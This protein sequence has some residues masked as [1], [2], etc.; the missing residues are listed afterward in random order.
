MIPVILEAAFRSLLMAAAVWAGIRM[1]RVQAVLAQK[2]AWV[3]VLLAAG[4]M[5]FVMRAPI[6]VAV[7]AIQIPARTV[8]RT[9][10]LKVERMAEPL[11]SQLRWALAMTQP[12]GAHTAGGTMTLQS[13]PATHAV[14]YLPKP[15]ATHRTE[16]LSDTVSSLIASSS[17]AGIAHTT[18]KASDSRKL[19]SVGAILSASAPTASSQR[20]GLFSWLR[21]H[22]P[23]LLSLTYLSVTAFLFF[24]TLAG[25]VVALRLWFRSKPVP[26]LQSMYVEGQ[27]RTGSVRASYDLATPVTIGSTVILPANFGEW[28][29]NKLRIVLAHERSHVR[30][31]DFYLQ[32]LAAAHVAVFWFSPLGWWLKRK[33]SE[34]GEALSDG[35]GLEAAPDASTYAQVLL[36][37][38]AMP[39]TAPVAGVPMARSGSLSTRIDRVLNLSRLK[40]ALAEGKRHIA[41]TASLVLVA[42]VA[43]VAC[44]RIV[45]PV[46]AAQAQASSKAQTITGT[47]SEGT[48]TAQAKPATAESME[49]V[50]AQQET[51]GQAGEGQVDQVAPVPPVPSVPTPAAVTTPVPDVAPVPPVLP[52]P[53]AA[54]ISVPPIPAMAPNNFAYGF[55]GDGDDDDSYA[56]IRG[57]GNVTLSGHPGKALEEAKRK[58]HNN[59][60][61][62]ERDGKSYVITDPS[63]LSQ[64]NSY[65]Q[66]NKSLE[67]EQARLQ[68]QQDELNR[69][70]KDFDPSKANVMANSPEMKKQMAELNR[71]LAELQSDK[72]KK[73]TDD[74][75]K[76]VNQDMLSDLQSKMGEIQAQIGELQGRIGEEMGRL[77]EKQGELGEQMGRLGEQM[78]RIGEEQGR[79][80]DQMNQRVQSLIDRAIQN[81][82]AKPVS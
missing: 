27:T 2:L 43:V 78:G 40:P 33:L 17:N 49:A 64:F 57:N 22:A 26:E 54:T 25:L 44:I 52:A 50:D 21:T 31:G 62:F 55:S 68:M 23:A 7:G 36:E 38:A 45:P 60:I 73:M 19:Q 47:A 41:L 5:P 42:L 9:E 20:L 16:T 8:F 1:M 65:D 12:L 39:R 24:R 46:E 14:A 34:L 76:Q 15:H 58:Y 72:F 59:F 6:P 66:R 30:Q 70:M 75:N 81:G 63:I 35:A 80:A 37:F 4:I 18:W 69:R 51:T 67:H 10:M 48:G 13:A 3:L 71:K 61:W 56:I 79:L 11:I 28:D 53:S 29:E 74:I 82:T 77:G 32:L